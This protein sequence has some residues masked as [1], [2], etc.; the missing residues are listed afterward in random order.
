VIA[1]LNLRKSS[2]LIIALLLISLTFI[3][4][5]CGG[6]KDGSTPDN[7]N[8]YKTWLSAD[9]TVNFG[10]TKYGSIA[11]SVNSTVTANSIRAAASDA[12]DTSGEYYY[13]TGTV[14]KKEVLKQISVTNV[15]DTQ[16]NIKTVNLDGS[17]TPPAA[18]P[19]SFVIDG[20]RYLLFGYSSG[21]FKLYVYVSEDDNNVYYKSS[22]T[23]D[24][25]SINS[26]SLASLANSITTKSPSSIAV[27]GMPWITNPVYNVETQTLYFT[28]CWKLDYTENGS[29]GKSVVVRPCMAVSSNGFTP[30]PIT[31][32]P[33]FDP[34]NEGMSNPF[35]PSRHWIG[36]M[37]VNKAGNKV[38]FTCMNDTD[39]GWGSTSNPFSPPYP[40]PIDADKRIWTYILTA[41]ING[42]TL[43]NSRQLSS[44]VNK[45]GINYVA[46]ISP[47]GS[48][49]YVAHMD[50]PSSMLAD[51]ASYKPD[52]LCLDLC[53]MAPYEIS[54]WTGQLSRVSTEGL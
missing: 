48:Y 43:S 11:V 14:G 10:L 49:L 31:I 4:S 50:I 1:L 44:T 22:N 47:D 35:H 2:F 18:Y 16:G 37:Y 8:G 19:N 26:S 17:T 13:I 6:G 52:G 34:E 28:L 25:S 9:G 23:L 24:F 30:A 51:N 39:I 29:K 7:T 21:T 33:E 15:T 27:F 46:D 42:G 3:L 54:V 36:R 40:Y 41:D 38:Y 20:T 5:S 45:A 53:N 12:A 32:P